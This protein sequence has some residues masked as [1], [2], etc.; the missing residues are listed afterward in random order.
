MVL[1]TIA[2]WYITANLFSPFATGN[3]VG[4]L[5]RSNTG[6]VN[7]PHFTCVEIVALTW[8]KNFLTFF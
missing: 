1:K 6:L 8:L 3:S 4:N 5:N 2:N 7:I